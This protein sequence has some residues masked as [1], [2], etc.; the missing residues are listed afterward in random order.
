MEKLTNSSVLMSAESQKELTVSSESER[1][2]DI[3]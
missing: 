3:N 1:I 2:V